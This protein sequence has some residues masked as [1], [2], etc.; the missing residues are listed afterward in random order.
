MS[1][2]VI[3]E[4]PNKIKSIE[5]YL[6]D[7]YKVM[8]S[9]GHIVKLPSSGP[10]SFGVDME[11]WEPQY[12][13]DDS[14]KT[15]VAELK[16]EAK[17]ADHVLIA[18]DPD[19]EGEAIGDNLITFL[20]IEKKYSRIRFN[21]I[22]KD[23]VNKSLND[24]GKIDSDLVNAQIARR[25]LDRV[26]GFKLS[27]LM[28][29]K[30]YNSPVSPSAGRVQ[31]IAL[32]L[33]NEREVQIEAFV[34]IK[35]KN[36]NAIIS[37][38][39]KASLYFPDKKENKM[40]VM[41]D[42]IEDVKK[43]LKGSL[44]VK[45][46]NISKRKDAKKTP[47]KQSAL[48]KMGDSSLGISSKAIQSSAQ[49]LYEGYGEGG[50]ISYPRTD[51]T[52]LSNTFVVA[53][54]SKIKSLYGKEYIAIDIKGIGGAQDAHEAIRPTDI[55]LFPNTARDRFNL[56]TN[57]YKVYKMI[58]EHTMKCLMTVP[59]REILRYELMEG[60]LNFRM[61]SSKIIFDGYYK[62]NP[63]ENDK[64]LPKFEKGEIVKVK[65]YLIDDHETQ[66]PARYNDGSL[67]EKL[68]SIKVGRPSTFATMVDVLKKREYVTVE[69]RAMK[70]T[71]FGRVLITKLLESFP[72][73][74]TEEYTS[75]LES[76]LNEIAEGQESRARWLG[77][78]W[79]SFEKTM[80]SATTSMEITRMMP[81]PAG[82]ECPKCG[83]QLIIRRNKKEGSR[84]FGCS[85]Y[86]ECVHTESDPSDKSRFR[87]KYN[88]KSKFASKTK[89]K[90]KK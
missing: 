2:L 25:I 37:D 73:I 49:R 45:S 87:R 48:Y 16:R 85:N 34:A 67:I 22:T 41:D 81:T 51:S 36:V 58:W 63:K 31:S 27:L 57:E 13:I 71:E 53:A 35:Y 9:V 70:I 14:K 78:F 8:A 38:D 20:N 54:Q 11:T 21:E 39:V 32:K 15:I 10:N 84:F 59:T 28:R 82:K 6:G 55:S 12:K 52:R 74:I 76:K 72:K 75:H 61:S 18:T 66:P 3:V 5:K 77:E 80:A 68:D 19:R 56:G 60:D 42:E 4:S 1:K 79:K 50:L 29:R 88:G 46:V 89:Y 64:Q 65:D 24:S 69:G 43:Q 83:E 17:K 23:A 7:G 40:W 30:I 44:T 86:P 33:V 62:I 90:K 26:I 47:L